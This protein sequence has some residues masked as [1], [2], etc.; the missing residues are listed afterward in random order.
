MPKMPFQSRTLLAFAVCHLALT[1]DAGEV[2]SRPR[3]RGWR[4]RGRGRVRFPVDELL[5]FFARLEVGHLLRRDVHL[6]PR[7]WVASLARL[8]PAQADAA[9]APQLDLLAAVERG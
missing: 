2:R 9:D 5:Q 3:D 6:V 1:L 8:A 4:G 7:L